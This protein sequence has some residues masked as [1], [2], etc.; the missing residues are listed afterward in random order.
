M[1]IL[2]PRTG[3][4]PMQPLAIQCRGCTIL[5]GGAGIGNQWVGKQ[6]KLA[7]VRQSSPVQ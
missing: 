6:A 4:P 2:D 1:V 5:S 3:Q 7:G